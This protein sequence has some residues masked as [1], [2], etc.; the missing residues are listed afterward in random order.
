MNRRAFLAATILAPLAAKEPPFDLR[1]AIAEFLA[2]FPTVE[3]MFRRN[4]AKPLADWT[5]MDYEIA[6]LR[7]R[8]FTNW[9]PTGL[10]PA[11]I[12]ERRIG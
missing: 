6:H 10:S 4:A 5:A 9:Q 8:Y 1:A 12:R 2:E 3:T 11:E 7:Y